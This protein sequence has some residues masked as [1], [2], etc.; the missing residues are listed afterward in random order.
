MAMRQRAREGAYRHLSGHVIAALIGGLILAAAA[1]L[2]PARA[3]EDPS[4]KSGALASGTAP[5]LPRVRLL[6]QEQ[7]FNSLGYIFGPDI[8][9]AA[10]FTP[11]RRTDGLVEAGASVAGVTSGQIDEFQ[12]T[13]IAIADQVVSPQHRSFLVPV[14]PEERACGGPALRGA[15]H[16]TASAGFSTAAR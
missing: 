10:H 12:R 13:A 1:F 5:S 16:S 9:V 4:A 15:V 14:Y 7:Y 11:F 8:S 2:S 3:A 6:S